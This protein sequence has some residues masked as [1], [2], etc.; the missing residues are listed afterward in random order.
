MSKTKKTIS[1]FLCIFI[2][3]SAFSGCSSESETIDFIYPFDGNVSSF[4]P[5]IA[6]TSDEFLIA[7]NC[8]EGLVRV[9]DDG[10]VQAGVAESWEISPDR[11]T[12]TFKLRQDAKWDIDTQPDENGERRED[13]RLEL[14][15]YDFNP[16]ITAHDFV[17]AL[18]R[19]V[20][21]NTGSPLY[22]SVSNIVNASQINSGEMAADK[23]G[24]K[25]IDN[26]TLEIKLQS[27]DEGFLNTLSTAVAM[28]CSEKFFNATKGRY[29]LGT[30]YTLFNGQFY[31]DMILDTSYVLDRNDLYVGDH[32]SAVSDLT[33]KIKDENSDIVKNLKNGYYDCAY[34]SGKEYEQLNSEKISAVPYSNKMWAFILNKNKLLFDNINLR[35]AVCLSISDVDSN[36]HK[37]LAQAKNFTPESC[38]INGKS[39][40]EAMGATVPQQDTQ[41]AAELWKKGLEETGYTAADLTVIVTEDMEEIAK[42][43]VQGIQGSI[44]K[45]S[46]YGKG[47]ENKIT[48]SLKIEV[49]NQEEFNTAF[50]KGEYDLA[51]YCF[52]ATSQSATSYL[53]SI[54]KG[55][56]AGEMEGAQEALE[57]A[58][59]SPANGKVDACRDLETMLMNDYSIMPVLFESS[60]YAQAEGVSGVQF[61]PG[62]GRVSFVNATRED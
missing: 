9:L 16:N 43:F 6:S 12:Y 18:R 44:G 22:S 45:I 41:K 17:F 55:N 7:E 13:S 33:L 50:S 37:Y 54:I 14:V 4:D 42:Q 59:N 51:L 52:E 11:L 24:V 5:Q 21:K 49:L 27:A 47:D 60:Y 10:T 48:F 34:I 31:V 36:G 20:D 19:A 15:G 32:P 39:A 23:L 26:Y 58:Q 57:T 40:T 1:L 61:H 25:A 46:A 53:E 28:P 38:I 35:Q 62:S 3:L 8:F 30:E 56:Y 2:I 29:G